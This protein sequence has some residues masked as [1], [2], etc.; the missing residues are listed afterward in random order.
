MKTAILFA[1]QGAQH[2]GMGKDFYAEYPGFRR[3]FD[4]LP[5]E[6]R[7]IAFEGPAEEL[8]KTE[9]TQPIMLAF[10]LGVYRV[11]QEHGFVPDMAAGLSLGEY[12]ALA[13]A[14]VFDDKTAV[15][16]ITFRGK[17]MAKASEGTDTVMSAVIGL[18][19]EAAENACREAQSEGDVEIANYNCPG[20]IVVSG[21]EAGVTACERNAKELGARRCI[22]LEVS[23]PF[24]T[25]YMKPAGKAL[26]EY[27]RGRTFGRMEFPVVFNCLGREKTG[28]ETV[29]ELLVRQVS[30]SVY[31]EDTIRYMAEH[32]VTGTLEIGPGRA[33][34]GF[35]RKTDRSI[36]TMNIET[37]ED[38][39][40]VI[41]WTKKQQ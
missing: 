32:G 21:T 24:H 29:S 19:R 5:E 1:G 31:F 14:G 38:L 8:K 4:L 12:S 41:A 23:G 15:E 26:A 2:V 27:F 20:Q 28:A 11:L 13:A 35:V 6:Q 40:K 16:L 25:S 39:R 3:V 37:T 30:G 17:Q 9:N 7:R 33:L 34:S 18:E 22:R 36:E 10:A